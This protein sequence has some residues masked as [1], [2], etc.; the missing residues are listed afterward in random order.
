MM[1]SPVFKQIVKSGIGLAMGGIG[2]LLMVANSSYAAIGTNPAKQIFLICIGML[3]CMV[4]PVFVIPAP[5]D[6]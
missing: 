3:M 4:S 1:R 2:G 5:Q 6:E